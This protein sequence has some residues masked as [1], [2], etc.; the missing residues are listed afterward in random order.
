[1]AEA[2]KF[3]DFVDLADQLTEQFF[4]QHYPGLDTTDLGKNYDGMRKDTE[5]IVAF[6]K[7]R[8]PQFF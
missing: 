8:L 5:K 1:V 7:A 6:L 4:L 3:D 2:R